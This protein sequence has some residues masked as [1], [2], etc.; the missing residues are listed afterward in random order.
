MVCNRFTTLG[1][2]S[3]THLSPQ[4]YMAYAWHWGMNLQNVLQHTM[5]TRADSKLN[6]EPRLIFWFISAHAPTA[7]GCW[8]EGGGRLKQFRCFEN[9]LVTSL[10]TPNCRQWRLL[11]GDYNM[12]SVCEWANGTACES[13]DWYVQADNIINFPCM[14]Y[15]DDTNSNRNSR[16]GFLRIMENLVNCNFIF[17]SWKTHGIWEKCQ[18]SWKTHGKNIRQ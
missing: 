12:G 8:G 13:E 3:I 2:N 16:S 15:S 6:L 11:E 1:I 14:A 18:N 5:L 4:K 10:D 9:W 7:H 17:Q